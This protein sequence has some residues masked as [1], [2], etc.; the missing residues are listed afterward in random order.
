MPP[1]IKSYCAIR[2]TRFAIFYRHGQQF[3]QLHK[4]ESFFQFCQLAGK[5][6]A[7]NGYGTGLLGA[8]VINNA[9]IAKNNR[10]ATRQ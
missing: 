7:R 3:I 9:V 2:P 10:I 5:V 6:S 1:I 8:F 4:G